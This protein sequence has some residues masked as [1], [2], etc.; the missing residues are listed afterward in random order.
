M[1]HLG[2]EKEINDKN[3]DAKVKLVD[4]EN[5]KLH[6]GAIVGTIVDGKSEFVG[7]GI[8]QD[9][10]SPGRIVPE[11]KCMYAPYG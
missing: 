5:G 11:E 9:E 1:S 4:C 7:R 2:E 6:A 10:I 3:K 8:T